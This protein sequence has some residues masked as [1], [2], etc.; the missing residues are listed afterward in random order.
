MHV[1]V[2]M[3]CASWV[4]SDGWLPRDVNRH[5]QLVCLTLYS[6]V[7]FVNLKQYNYIFVERQFIIVI[8]QVSSRQHFDNNNNNIIIIHNFRVPIVAFQT[9]HTLF[10]VSHPGNEVPGSKKNNNN[11][12][13]YNA[14]IVKH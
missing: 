9:P 14:H 2:Y 13:I 7:D 8:I 11:V 5:V 3:H 12:K 6:F 10:N 4:I 1:A